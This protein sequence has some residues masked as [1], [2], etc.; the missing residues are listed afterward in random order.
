MDAPIFTI[1]GAVSGVAGVAGL[2]IA[3]PS[4]KSRIIHFVYCA[5]IAGL[6]ASAI[7]YYGKYQSGQE[8]QRSAYE[9]VESS[10]SNDSRGFMLATLALLE[11]NKAEFPEMYTSAKQLCIEAGLTGKAA[12]ISTADGARAMY[13]LL[14]GLSNH[15]CCSNGGD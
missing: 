8:L 6:S 11:R 1:I 3:L 4:T 5:A 13:S 7:F 15:Y 10:A 14:R 9:L 12:S 2:F